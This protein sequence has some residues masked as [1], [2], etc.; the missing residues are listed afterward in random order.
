[1]EQRTVR[2]SFSHPASAKVTL[3]RES[4]EY[5]WQITGVREIRCDV[6]ARSLGECMTE[7]D[8]FAMDRSAANAREER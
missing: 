6:T 5:A 3:Q 2:I 7:N 4:P 1:M 8:V